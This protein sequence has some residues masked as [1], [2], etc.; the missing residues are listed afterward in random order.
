M[1]SGGDAIGGSGHALFADGKARLRPRRAVYVCFEG[2]TVSVAA[3]GRGAEDDGNAFGAEAG[4][5]GT[6]GVFYL[7]ER[8]PK[9]AV[10]VGM[11]FR[12]QVNRQRLPVV[13]GA[14]ANGETASG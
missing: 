13:H 1:I 7:A 9:Q 14:A 12:R 6:D 2:S 4:D 3:T 5:G 8:L 11:V 10:V